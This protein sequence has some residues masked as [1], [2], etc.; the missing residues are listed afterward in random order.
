M[1]A[2]VSKSVSWSVEN[3]VKQKFLKISCQLGERVY[4][5]SEDI[6]EVGYA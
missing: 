2:L 1:L 4:G 6:F 5:W 3:S